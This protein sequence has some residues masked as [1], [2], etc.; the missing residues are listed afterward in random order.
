MPSERRISLNLESLEPR[1]LLSVPPVVTD[2]KISTAITT[3]A[4]TA[5][6]ANIGDK[7]KVIWNNSASGDNN[8]GITGVKANLSAFGGP[9]AAVMNDSGTGGDATAGDG[10]WTVTYTV[11]PGNINATN[12]NASVTATDGSAQSTTTAD[13]SNITVNNGPLTT[14]TSGDTVVSVYDV[15]DSG[16][17]VASD[18]KVKFGVNDGV[19]VLA[20]HGTDDMSGL[21][22]VIA[23]APVVNRI[24]DHRD[25]TESD[26]SFIASDTFIRSMKLDSGA[27]GF[28]LNG[29]TLGGLTF[30]A[31]V[32]SDGSVTDVTAFY[33]TDGMGRAKMQG[34]LS[35]EVWLGGMDTPGWTL[36]K[37]FIKGGDL[38]ADM[39]VVGDAGRIRVLG[40]D[41]DANVTVEGD[42]Y[43]LL[44]DRNNGVGGAL[45]A[46]ANV[47]VEGALGGGH[48]ASYETD[49][50][51]VDYGLDLG[52]LAGRLRL[53]HTF[54]HEADLPFSDGDFGVVSA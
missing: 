48:M 53:G 36:G 14:F 46:G 33:N 7:I 38:L 49:N 25:G 19:R 15:T 29:L 42:L 13:T 27:T 8:S 28:N 51:N 31:D 2:L 39:D 12:R 40:G 17:F 22:I 32:D 43:R 45:M 10:I 9:A 3:D 50:N 20:L 24:R 34:D 18:I 16:D 41:V 1:L 35:G 37:W 44:L 21:G 54:L 11:L 30:A 4:G 6:V 23:G 52:S 26:I 5:G 47:T